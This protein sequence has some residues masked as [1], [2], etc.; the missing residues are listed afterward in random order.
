MKIGIIGAGLAGATAARRLSDAGHSVCVLEKSGGT[1]GRLSTRRSDVGLFDHGAQYLSA[2][3]SAFQVLLDEMVAAGA[4]ERWSP[5]GQD[6]PQQWYRGAP[7]MSG[8]V[9]PMLDG[10]DVR[11]RQ[12]VNA[13]ETQGKTVAVTTAEGESHQFDRLIVCCPTPQARVLV[14]ALDDAF[15]AL[16]DVTYAPCWTAMLAFE[17]KVSAAPDVLR[18][19]H[20]QPLGWLTRENAKRGAR[21]YDCFT[22]QAGMDWSATHLERDKED[23]AREMAAHFATKFDTNVACV[24]AVAHRWRYAAVTQSAGT[25]FISGCD[26]HILVAGDGLLGGRAEAAFDSG[27]AAA[28]FLCAQIA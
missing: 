7:G 18:G 11:N 22:M 26:H 23:V 13:V 27:R 20:D 2:K 15:A 3:G 14:G 25:P 12:T 6:R 28:E 17:E 9:K 4:A 24:S 8:L 5:K 21:G 19:A 10:I 16:D 1:G